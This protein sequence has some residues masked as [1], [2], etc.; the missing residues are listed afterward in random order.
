MSQYLDFIQ[1]GLHTEFAKQKE[2]VINKRIEELGLQGEF[3]KD[4]Y[5]TF[6][7]FKIVEN[8]LS[9]KYYY[10]NGTEFAYLII[11][12]IKP[13]FGMEKKGKSYYLTVK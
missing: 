11:E 5:R 7:K 9:W 13:V 4:K 1:K 2:D 3:L 8:K 10:D 12:I 6:R